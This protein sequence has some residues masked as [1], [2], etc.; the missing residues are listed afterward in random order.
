MIQNHVLADRVTNDA[1]KLDNALNDQRPTLGAPPQQTV[2]SPVPLSL[3]GQLPQHH[4]RRVPKSPPRMF[5]YQPL[6]P[7]LSPGNPLSLTSPIQPPSPMSIPLSRGP[8]M[9]MFPRAP[10]GHQDINMSPGSPPNYHNSPRTPVSPLFIRR[11]VNH[12]PVNHQP[13]FGERPFPMARATGLPPQTG[14]IHSAQVSGSPNH[15][16]QFCTFTGDYSIFLN[17]SS[18]SLG[19][20]PSLLLQGP[21]CS[22][23]ARN[24][25]LNQGPRVFSCE[26]V[27]RAGRPTE[28]PQGGQV[29]GFPPSPTCE[30]SGL[31]AIEK[32]RN[33]DAQPSVLEGL[34]LL[35]MNE[36][37]SSVQRTDQNEIVCSVEPGTNCATAS[38]SMSLNKDFQ[39]FKTPPKVENVAV[40]TMVRICD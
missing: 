13:M 29:L 3:H 2:V 19:S 1:S 11:P 4:V 18:A 38:C 35:K 15:P 23:V 25:I 26:E 30:A 12:I 27:E 14:P 16:F 8:V 34:R 40:T 5:K 28:F 33:T 9:G 22:P 37:H 10:F 6:S 31:G 17:N 24:N 36:A 7:P 21:G 39:D 32:T 20:P